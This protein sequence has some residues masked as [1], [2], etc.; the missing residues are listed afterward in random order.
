MTMNCVP[1]EFTA[2][3]NDARSTLNSGVTAVSRITPASVAR[4]VSVGELA[5]ARPDSSPRYRASFPIAIVTGRHVT[6]SLF[7]C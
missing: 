1:V 2:I 7:I 5:S 6:G 4:A 3:P